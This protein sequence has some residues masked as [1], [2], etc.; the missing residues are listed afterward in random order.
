[1][2]FKYNLCQS[3]YL[4]VFFNCKVYSE[5]CSEK[6]KRSS[7]IFLEGSGVF[8]QNFTGST[9]SAILEPRTGQI[10]RT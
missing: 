3:A 9:N 2:T 10:S 7:Q 5:K 6:Q 1:M 8:Q 4:D